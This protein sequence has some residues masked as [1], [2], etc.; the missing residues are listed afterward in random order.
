MKIYNNTGCRFGVYQASRN[1]LGDVPIWR[2]DYSS[3][4]GGDGSKYGGVRPV[5][6]LNQGIKANYSEKYDNNYNTFTISRI[7]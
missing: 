5:I 4:G 1:W 7:K 6:E 3:V 2:N